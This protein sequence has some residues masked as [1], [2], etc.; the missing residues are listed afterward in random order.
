MPSR[1][2]I[3]ILFLILVVGCR[4]ADQATRSDNA[5]GRDPAS[6]T[7]E[8]TNGTPPPEIT[9]QVAGPSASPG[10][11]PVPERTP[12]PGPAVRSSA[13]LVGAGDIA[14]CD[15][16]G[17]EATAALLDGIPGT[18]FT[19]GDNAY[20]HGTAAEFAA[21]YAPSWGRHRER[22][23]PAAGNHDYL[24]PGA[25][26]YFAYFGAAAGEPGRGYYSYDIGDWHVVVLNSN[27]WAVAGCHAGSVQ[28]RWL[29]A[30]L[31]AHPARCTLAYWHHPRFSSGPHGGDV[32]VAPLWQALYEAGAEIVING[33]DHIYERFAPQ[34]PSG[35]PDAARGIRQFVVGTGGR[36]LYSVRGTPAATS[37]LRNS[38]TFGV[39]KLTLHA[40]GYEWEFVPVAGGAF[41]DRGSG[42]CH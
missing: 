26:P 25:A 13:V 5:D 2:G 6:M 30:D 34:D 12:E 15:S 10:A 16:T 37:E 32:A 28:E 36:S 8:Q 9:A 22:T 33:H 38:A 27:C 18:V 11:T 39:L 1:V 20:E 7:R 21:C 40:E 14:A 17:D 4:G 23:R 31:A 3:F 35:A 24:M 29:R 42:V 41:T 19:A